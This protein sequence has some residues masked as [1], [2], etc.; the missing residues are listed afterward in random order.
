MQAKNRSLLILAAA[1][2]F[3]VCTEGASFAYE[4]AAHGRRDPF[5][6][7]VGVEKGAAASGLV[8][9]YSIED[10]SLQGI[11]NGPGG[12]KGAIINGEFVKEGDKVERVY[13]ESVGDNVVVIKI[14]EDRHELKL[15]E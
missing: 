8:G 6:P 4:Y 10:V 11:V 15:Y 14:D 2:V 9:V 5:V 3:S 12:K 1:L 7:L 13:I